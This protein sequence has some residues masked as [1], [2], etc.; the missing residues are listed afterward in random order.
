M[1]YKGIYK[2]KNLLNGKVYIGQSIDIKRRFKDHKKEI[3]NNNVYPLYHS[4]RKYGIEN[5]EFNVIEHVSNNDELNIKE[6]FWVD[7]YKS[8]N[9]SYG[10]N[11]R[12]DC[13]NNYGVLHSEKTKQDISKKLRGIKRSDKTKEKMSLAKKGK[14]FTKESR[15]KMSN[16]QK[17]IMTPERAKWVRSFRKNHFISALTKS[18]I[19]RANSQKTRTNAEKDHLRK[20]NLGKKWTDAHRSN[21]NKA[22]EQRKKKNK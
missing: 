19:G 1:K 3:K 8:F 7:Y 10:Y 11:I 5:F 22:M 14:I 2:I 9:R 4:I 18:K 12:I 15:A 16:A 13:T 20:I 17:A 6:Q 21:Y